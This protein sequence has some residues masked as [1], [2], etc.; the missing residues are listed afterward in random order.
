MRNS[1]RHLN[2]LGPFAKEIFFGGC[3]AS[4]SMRRRCLRRLATARLQQFYAGDVLEMADDETWPAEFMA[5]AA[6]E[7]K[8]TVR[9]HRAV[10]MIHRIVAAVIEAEAE[11]LRVGLTNRQAQFV[12]L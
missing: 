12:L 4:A 3:R 1:W 5:G 9:H 8:R 11:R 10:G 6:A 2:A 7:H